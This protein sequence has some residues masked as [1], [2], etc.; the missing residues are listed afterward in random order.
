MSIRQGLVLTLVLAGIAAA[1]AGAHWLATRDTK[2]PRPV[3]VPASS[4]GLPRSAP[5][6]PLP[7]AGSA[8]DAMPAEQPVTEED[9]EPADPYDRCDGIEPAEAWV[10]C[11]DEIDAQVEI[12]EAACEPYENT[13]WADC[14]EAARQLQPYRAR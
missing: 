6:G 2:S 13:E 9:A 4:P 5:P 10:A 1:G 7:A 11:T 3:A 8:H 14:M 12:L